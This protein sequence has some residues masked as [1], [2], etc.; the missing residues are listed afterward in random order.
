MFDIMKA[1]DVMACA[2]AGWPGTAVAGCREIDEVHC[3]RR[4]KGIAT[5]IMTATPRPY[6]YQD[7]KYLGGAEAF[8]EKIYKVIGQSSL[9]E[10]IS[11]YD[12]EL[13]CQFMHCF[14]APSDAVLLSEGIEGDHLMV[15]LSGQV[16]VVKHDPSGQP[17]SLARVGPGSI[18]GEMSLIDGEHRFASCIARGPVQFAILTR[19]DLAEILS[20]HPRLGNKLLIW[21]LQITIS[22][23]RDTDLQLMPRIA[24][25]IA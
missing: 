15:I 17:V 24:N 1:D 10:R 19:F 13:L 14:S 18:L 5:I 8:A 11:L 7:L 9:Y 3:C 25:Q 21:I 20:A 16:Q 2:L 22:R 12:C 6:L 23:V 4:E